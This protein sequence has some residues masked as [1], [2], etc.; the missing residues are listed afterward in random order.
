MKPNDTTNILNWTLFDSLII[1]IRHAHK[2][3]TQ[4]PAVLASTDQDTAYYKE[5]I[6]YSNVD[7]EDFSERDFYMMM[8]AVSMIWVTA[9]EAERKQKMSMEELG[10]VFMAVATA[11]FGIISSIAP[12]LLKDL[13][14]FH[15]DDISHFEV[16]DYDEDDWTDD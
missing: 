2:Q 10:G 7:A 13:S 11:G 14:N 1:A 6:S 16:D 4:D 5:L 15:F 9:M 8:L 3:R 12:I